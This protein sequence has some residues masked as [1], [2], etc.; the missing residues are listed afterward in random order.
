[1]RRDFCNCKIDKANDACEECWS[2]GKSNEEEAQQPG[3]EEG[4]QNG[5]HLKLPVDESRD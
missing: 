4:E 1:L 2:T 3:Q 5:D